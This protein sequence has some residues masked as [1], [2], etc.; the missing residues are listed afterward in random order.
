VGYNFRSV[1]RDQAYLL[2]PSLRDWL[3]PDEL[4]WLVLDVVEQVDLEPIRARYRSDGWGAP[5]FDPALMTAL[6][7]YAYATGERSSRRIEALCRRDIAYRVICANQCPDHTTI[8]RF[9]ADHEVALAGL[10]GAILRLCR[11]AGLGALGLVAIDGTRLAAD[12]SGDRNRTAEALDAEIAAILAAH[13]AT[14]AAEDAAF[15]PERRGDELPEGLADPRS[16]LARLVEARRQLAAAEAAQRAAYAAAVAR[17]ADPDRRPGGRPAKPDAVRRQRSVRRNTTDPDSRTLRARTGWI[18]GYNGQVAVADDGLIVAAEL[19]QAANDVDQLVPLLE[20]AEANVA[21]AGYPGRIGLI[22]AD[23]GY[24]SEANLASTERPGH[25]RLLIPP[26]GGK[27]RRSGSARPVLA[28][29]ARMIR[30]LAQPAMATRYRR[31][32]AIVEPVFGQ[33][34]EVRGV[35]R[36]RRRGLVACSSEWQLLCATHNLLKLWRYGR[37]GGPA[38]GP[39]LGPRPPGPRP[40]QQAGHRPRDRWATPPN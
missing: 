38:G 9:R 34:K 11:A 40:A 32:Q 39:G 24:W 2:P 21:A 7:L 26:T 17:A 16:R 19:T 20:Q 31:R 18:V 30:R 37:W 13:G 28:G 29:R 5:A 12:A 36:F 15:G 4:A 3:P 6:L 14:D 33:L 8:A 23:A 35:R 27:P 25:P 1:E 22:L 10:F